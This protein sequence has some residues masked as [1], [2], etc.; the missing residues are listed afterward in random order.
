MSLQIVFFFLFTLDVT[1]ASDTTIDIGLRISIW[2]RNVSKVKIWKE[3]D[4]IDSNLQI[5]IRY[6]Y[7]PKYQKESMF[8]L[9][10]HV[11]IYLL[12]G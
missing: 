6:R 9:L 3:I 11:D 8:L 5:S 2:Y 1:S 4:S 7:I 12:L 10:E